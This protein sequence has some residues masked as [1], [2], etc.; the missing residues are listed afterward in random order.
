MDNDD[1]GHEMVLVMESVPVLNE[2]KPHNRRTAADPLH[3]QIINTLYSDDY[4]KFR[5]LLKNKKARTFLF[6]RDF[7]GQSL[8]D[9]ILEDGRL[10]N[11]KYIS[12]VIIHFDLNEDDFFENAETWLTLVNKSESVAN[13]LSFLIP[14]WYQ[15]QTKTFHFLPL[16]AVCFDNTSGRSLCS[17]LINIIDD[18]NSYFFHDACFRTIC[19]LLHELSYE[20]ADDFEY[21]VDRST[22]EEAAA[23]INEEFRH[24]ILQV[25]LV[26]LLPTD[27]E[28]IESFESFIQPTIKSK[29][30]KEPLLLMF[31][32]F[33]SEIHKFQTSFMDFINEAKSTYGDYYIFLVKPCVRL[34][35][36]IAKQKEMH[37]TEIFIQKTFPQVGSNPNIMTS[38]YE[39]QELRN[40]IIK[41]FKN[42][43]IS[44]MV[45]NKIYFSDAEEKI[46]ILVQNLSGDRF[47]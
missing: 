8:F 6:Q 40:C 15:P 38:I 20:N 2:N 34:L 18:E 19:Q 5:K 12:L 39:T 14:D 32:L 26:Y 16:K 41:P 27:V 30:T 13:L 10:S 1:R 9:E 17:K 29:N 24:Q 7:D 28:E 46:Q 3:K 45:K 35:L 22:L 33:K 21:V 42:Q 11:A 36:M 47:G 25:L 23:M 31:N 37:N 4:E 43:K 44:R